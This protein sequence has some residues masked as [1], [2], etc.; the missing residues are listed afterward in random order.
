MKTKEE[1]RDERQEER[2]EERREDRRE[3]RRERRR[4]SLRHARGGG[5]PPA[6][7][8]RLLGAR[9]TSLRRG[10]AVPEA[11]DRQASLP[12]DSSLRR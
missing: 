10:R 9:D 1:R 2:R 7:V 5:R 12:R 4:C 6:E 3:E 8:G 11:G